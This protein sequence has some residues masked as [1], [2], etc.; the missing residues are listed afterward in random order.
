MIPNIYPAGRA[1]TLYTAETD[2]FKTGLFSVLSTLPITRENAV[3]APLL[4]SVLRRGT[5][6]YPTLSDISRRLDWL[7][8]AGFSVRASYRG[9]LLVVGFTANLLDSSYLPQ[10]SGD[11]MGGILD[12][13]REILFAPVRDADGRFRRLTPKAKRGCSAT[14]S[15]RRRTIRAP[16]RRIVAAQSYTIPSRAAFRSGA[17]KRKPRLSRARH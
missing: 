8:G 9:N 3:F 7:W 12:L 17:V 4:L 1:A 16:M 6:Q 10:D 5:Q 11:L 2:R 14:P 15:A 13:M